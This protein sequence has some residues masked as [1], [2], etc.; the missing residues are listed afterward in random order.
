MTLDKLLGLGW[1]KYALIASIVAALIFGVSFL[2]KQHDKKVEKNYENKIQATATKQVAIDEKDIKKQFTRPND[3]IDGAVNQWLQS[4]QSAPELLGTESGSAD[5]RDILEGKPEL[6]VSGSLRNPEPDRKKNNKSEMPCN[7]F[8]VE[9]LEV[10][11]KY[12][13]VCE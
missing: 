5:T 2:I 1:I 13:E 6:D 11:G 4:N 9:D 3:S 10:E 12:I 8:Y 7:G